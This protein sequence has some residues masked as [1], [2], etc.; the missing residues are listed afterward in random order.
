MICFEPV[1]VSTGLPYYRRPVTIKVATNLTRRVHFYWSIGDV[2]RTRVCLPA[3]GA[4]GS[5][6]AGGSPYST[7]PARNS[8]FRLLGDGSSHQY[9][10]PFERGKEAIDG[11][12][13]LSSIWGLNPW[14]M[15]VLN[16]TRIPPKG[17]KKQEIVAPV[18][19]GSEVKPW[20]DGS[21]HHYMD[22]SERG[23]EA[24]DGCTCISRIWG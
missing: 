10:D 6:L 4:E 2:G 24:R 12:A 21:S 18:Y 17:G 23:K 20:R 15:G 3:L 22:L 11:C 5:L 16:I 1:Q 19:Q 9:K 7:R 14:E 13:C 8:T